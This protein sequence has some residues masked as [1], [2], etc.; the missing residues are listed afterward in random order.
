M[1]VANAYFPYTEFPELFMLFRLTVT[2]MPA[3]QLYKNLAVFTSDLETLV[4]GR[5]NQPTT[6]A[7]F[8][9]FFGKQK[10]FLYCRDSPHFLQGI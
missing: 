7:L 6:E 2:T 9:P 3:R 8:Y 10:T 5:P 1:S 4:T